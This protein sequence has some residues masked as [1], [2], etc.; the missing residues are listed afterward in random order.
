MI[1]I[2]S[3]STNSVTLRLNENIVGDTPIFLFEFECVQ[4]GGITY[5]IPTDQS[6]SSK[7][8]VFE[9]R[10]ISDTG[11]TQSLTASIPF[12]ELEYGGYYNY[13]VYETDNYS[14]DPTDIILDYGKM[15]FING[16]YNSFFFEISEDEFFNVFDEYEQ[17]SNFNDEDKIFK[18][19]DNY[20]NEASFFGYKNVFEVFD[21]EHVFRV[22]TTEIYSQ[23]LKTEEGY[24]ISY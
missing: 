20:E 8:N 21:P 4:S 3:G 7:Y 22:L 24:T 10:E 13:R 6:T 11:L 5:C 14:L 17:E 18:V 15:V 19:F 23:A 9:I 16:E 1:T 2:N 12:I